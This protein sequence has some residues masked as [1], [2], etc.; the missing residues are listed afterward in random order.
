M[1]HFNFVAGNEQYY[2]TSDEED[3]II[4]KKMSILFLT[5]CLLLLY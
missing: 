3:N 2:E 5:D 1:K 4:N